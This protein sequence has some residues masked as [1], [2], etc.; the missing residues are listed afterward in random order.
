MTVST[1][2]NTTLSICTVTEL[3]H[4][5]RIALATRDQGLVDRMQTLVQGWL[6]PEYEKSVLLCLIRQ[7]QETVEDLSM[8]HG[9]D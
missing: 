3:H 5:I 7:L 2:T 4:A 6:V 9:E 8:Y 1:A